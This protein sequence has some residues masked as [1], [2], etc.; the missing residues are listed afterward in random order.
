[1][2]LMMV[3]PWIQV[4]F[5]VYVGIQIPYM[6]KNRVGVWQRLMYM[7][8]VRDWKKQSLAGETICKED[9]NVK[10]L[11]YPGVMKL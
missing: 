2:N 11:C 3:L 8:L 4:S 5:E 1:M 7:I 9:V 10:Y 6:G